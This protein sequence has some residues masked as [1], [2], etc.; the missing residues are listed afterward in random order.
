[1]RGKHRSGTHHGRH[2]GLGLRSWDDDERL[3][4]GRGGRERAFEYGTLRFVVLQLIAEKPSHG[5]ELIKAIEASTDGGYSPSPGV[6]YPTLA[7]LEDMGCIAASANDDN[8][9]LYKITAAG[10]KHLVDNKTVVEETLSRL[11]AAAA[12][13]GASES[14]QIIRAMH[15]LKTALRLRVSKGPWGASQIQ[16]LADALDA[17]AAAIERI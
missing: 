2:G 4:R 17:A 5:Y 7:M 14:P 15:N 3:W 9:K 13:R 8:R 10:K 11:R 6:V 16:A 12:Q 1:M